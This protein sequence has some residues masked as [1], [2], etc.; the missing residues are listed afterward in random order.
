MDGGG[1]GY[2]IA[3]LLE[4]ARPSPPPSPSEW[5]VSW[6]RQDEGK[7][8]LGFFRFPNFAPFLPPS[9]AGREPASPSFV[10]KYTTDFSLP[11]KLALDTTF[12]ESE[13][14]GKR[15]E[16]ELDQLFRKC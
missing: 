10:L 2:D 11:E 1:G 7:D 9:K 14:G 4:E 13:E 3:V 12:F 6:G 5:M 8:S 16:R 15:R